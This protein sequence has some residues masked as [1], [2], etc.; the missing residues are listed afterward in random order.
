MPTG[1]IRSGWVKQSPQW[2]FRHI[3]VDLDAYI[4]DALDAIEYALSLIHIYASA[5]KTDKAGR[6]LF[7]IL[8][9]VFTE[10]GSPIVP[11]IGRKQGNN[12]Y[13][14][15]SFRH[16]LYGKHSTPEM[17]IRDRV[18]V[19]GKENTP[20]TPNEVQPVE[21]EVGLDLN[22]PFELEAASM[23]VYRFKLK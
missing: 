4:Q 1:M 22:Q 19:P 2:N 3:D 23:V 15:L 20:F 7:Q 17:C 10:Y 11:G 16:R 14:K 21:T 13:L 6:K 18:L 9:N 5:R 12:I 8:N